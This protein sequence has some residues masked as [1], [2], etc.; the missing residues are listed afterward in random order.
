MSFSPGIFSSGVND[1]FKMSLILAWYCP[2]I[3]FSSIERF[4]NLEI[5]SSILDF[6]ITMVPSNRTCKMSHASLADLMA[7]MLLNCVGLTPL[8]MA[9]GAFQLLDG[10]LSS[11]D[12]HSSSLLGTYFPYSSFIVEGV[13]PIK[14]AFL[15]SSSIDLMNARIRAFQYPLLVRSN[16]GG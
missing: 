15:T 3:S 9:L 1:S 14:I 12:D 5:K 2:I 8:K 7:V 11:S 13:L 6:H 10:C 16:R 4:S